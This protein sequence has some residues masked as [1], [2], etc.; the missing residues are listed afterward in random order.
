MRHLYLDFDIDGQARLASLRVFDTVPTPTAVLS[1][2][3]GRYQI[4]CDIDS[5]TFEQQEKAIEP[6]AITFGGDPVCTDCNRVL[7]LPRF[8][9]CKYEPPYPVTVKY[10]RDS[11]SNPVTF[12]GK[13]RQ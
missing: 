7:R 10:P 12:G 6:L 2:S 8:R 13:F 9:N 5:S 11:T 3:L 1:T 4:L